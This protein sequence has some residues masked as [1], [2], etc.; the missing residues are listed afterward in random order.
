MEEDDDKLGH[1]LYGD[2]KMDRVR[3]RLDD[4]KTLT[5]IIHDGRVRR[6]RSSEIAEDIVKFLKEE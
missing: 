1:L 2:S 5:E 3:E 4:L 6:L